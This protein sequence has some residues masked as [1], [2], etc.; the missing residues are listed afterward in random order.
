MRDVFCKIREDGQEII[1][2]YLQYKTQVCKQT[3][4]DLEGWEDERLEETEQA[5]PE[6]VNSTE[7]MVSGEFREQYE[8][9]NNYGME[10][11]ILSP[12]EWTELYKNR[13]SAC[14]NFDNIMFTYLIRKVCADH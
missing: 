12:S 2:Q 6:Y 5:W 3:Y 1:R 8:S 13:Y 7:L 14:K 11:E 9:D 4:D 10:K